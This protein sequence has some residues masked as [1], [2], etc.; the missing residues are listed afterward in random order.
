MTLN[1]PVINRARQVLWVV[2]GA[3]K[4]GMLAR[5]LAGDQTISAG[6]V[7]QGNA[8]VFADRAAVCR[9]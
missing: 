9:L 6:R 4:A 1:F 5:L 7:E 2:T 8:L 3:E